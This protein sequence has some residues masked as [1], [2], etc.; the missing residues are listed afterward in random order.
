KNPD[1]K[2]YRTVS[3]GSDRF[4]FSHEFSE[5]GTYRVKLEVAK[6]GE[7]ASDVAI[8]NVE[9]EKKKVNIN[10]EVQSLNANP[11]EVIITA[12]TDPKYPESA[13]LEYT[14]AAVNKRTGDPVFVRTT[15]K[16]SIHHTFDDAGN[17]RIFAQV[18]LDV[19][20]LEEE[21]E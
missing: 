7:T 11:N 13:V 2:G 3:K 12:S 18:K 9:K 5:A 1:K 19:G 4:A 17:Y 14:F 21:S 15:E 10:V 16:K 20:E 8:V 6:N